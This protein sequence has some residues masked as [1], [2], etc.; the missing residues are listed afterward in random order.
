MEAQK[1]APGRPKRTDDETYLSTPGMRARLEYDYTNAP[2]VL[3]FGL[4]GARGVSRDGTVMVEGEDGTTISWEEAMGHISF[5][6]D[7]DVA[8]M[9]RGYR[10][11]QLEDKRKSNAYCHPEPGPGRVVKEN[12]YRPR[13]LQE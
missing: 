2:G 10:E 12:H 11:K 6:S 4:V 3:R 5:R 1:R 9:I 13:R 8:E 7:D